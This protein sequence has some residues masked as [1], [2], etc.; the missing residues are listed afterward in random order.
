MAPFFVVLCWVEQGLRLEAEK[1]G[2]PTADV[3][4]VLRLKGWVHVIS[5]HSFCE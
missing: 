3:G 5:V 2:M 4:Y 1:R